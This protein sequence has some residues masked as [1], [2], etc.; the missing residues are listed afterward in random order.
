MQGIDHFY[1]DTRFSNSILQIGEGLTDVLE[2]G[3]C[4]FGSFV[5][6]KHVTITERKFN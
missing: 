6:N 2:D 5:E 3:R 1:R 4:L